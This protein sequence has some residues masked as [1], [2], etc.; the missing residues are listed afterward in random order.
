MKFSIYPHSIKSMKAG[1]W[2][3]MM[4]TYFEMLEADAKRR[5]NETRMDSDKKQA[6][7]I[8]LGDF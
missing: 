1:A 7:N 3:N 6:S 2:I 8:D 5:E 4:N